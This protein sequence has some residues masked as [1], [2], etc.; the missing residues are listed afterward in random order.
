MRYRYSSFLTWPSICLSLINRTLKNIRWLFSP[1]LGMA[2]AKSVAVFF[3][4]RYKIIFPIGPQL[5]ASCLHS[6]WQLFSW[7][8]STCSLTLRCGGLCSWLF[9][10]VFT[11]Q[12]S[13]FLWF[14]CAASILIQKACLSSAS[15]L[16]K[17]LVSSSSYWFKV[18]SKL[19]PSTTITS[20]FVH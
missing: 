16:S 3:S 19:R 20:A 8:S 5:L 18:K 10:G 11:T 14:A 6:Q 9:H 7:Y 15:Q 2:L 1:W 12:D 13:P 4:A 17:I